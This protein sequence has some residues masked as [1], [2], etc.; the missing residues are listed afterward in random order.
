MA[1]P[2]EVLSPRQNAR[3]PSARYTAAVVRRMV[4]EAPPEEEEVVDSHWRRTLMME[5]GESNS[6]DSAV[7]VVD[8]TT[9]VLSCA[10]AGRFILWS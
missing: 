3:S 1:I 6:E 10:S 8:A 4:G 5:S 2:M 7:A 9:C